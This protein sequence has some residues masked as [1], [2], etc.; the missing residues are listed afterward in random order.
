[1]KSVVLSLCTASFITLS[2]APDL[3]GNGG[4]SVATL[5]RLRP[6]S[7]EASA[8]C[9]EA[10]KW[11]LAAQQDHD[12]IAEFN[13]GVL[14]ARGRSVAKDY[15]EAE[16]WFRKAAE[17]GESAAEFNLGVM[18]AHGLGAPQDYVTAYIWLS[19]AAEHG[20]EFAKEALEDAAAKMTQAE[21]ANAERVVA[22]R[23]KAG[24]SLQP[25]DLRM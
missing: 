10:G 18:Y 5:C 15:V 21:I 1:M 19:L 23:V 7:L 2:G 3:E 6:L 16:K 24:Q 12:P 20:Q 8:A 11:A 4:A 14:Y 13:L 22:Q 25:K 17:N 9:A